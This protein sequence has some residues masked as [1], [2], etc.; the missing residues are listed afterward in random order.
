MLDI[1]VIN[2]IYKFKLFYEIRLSK[3]IEEKSAFK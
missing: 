1:F 2:F 3:F